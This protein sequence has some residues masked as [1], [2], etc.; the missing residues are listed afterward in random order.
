[1]LRIGFLTTHPIQYHAPFFRHLSSSNDVKVL[2]CHQATAAEQAA[3]GFGVPFDWDISLLEG[4]EH[5]F[6]K[7]IAE[8]PSIF[9]FGGLDTPEIRQIVRQGQFD[10]LV[11]HG[12]NYK[13]A[14]Q[15]INACWRA[16]V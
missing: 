6:L 3:A 14:W 10:A 4:Y 16:G 9:G 2:Y 11:V 1:M 7:N 5:Q 15:G 8:K 12:W 13:S